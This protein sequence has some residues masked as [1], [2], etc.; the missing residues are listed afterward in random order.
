MDFAPGNLNLIFHLFQ[1]QKCEQGIAMVC[2]YSPSNSRSLGNSNFIVHSFP[3]CQNHGTNY[4]R[5]FSLSPNLH[6]FSLVSTGLTI[7]L[8]SGAIDGQASYPIIKIIEIN[9][10]WGTSKIPAR[11]L[12]ENWSFSHMKLSL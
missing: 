5:K 7:P 4:P 1:A 2:I 8:F 12:A 11:K 3:E 10:S 6:C 9:L